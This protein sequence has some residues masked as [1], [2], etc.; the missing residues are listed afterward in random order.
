[1]T[2][3]TCPA[4][5]LFP[6]IALAVG[7]V[8]FGACGPG[9]AT[10]IDVGPETLA[11]P[12]SSAASVD[13]AADGAW[14]VETDASWL[15][16]ESDEGAF[17]ETLEVSVV[18]DE[19]EA[20]DYEGHI[21]VRGD[22]ETSQTIPVTM[23]FPDVTGTV[24]DAD[25]TLQARRRV[26]E[27][28]TADL[29]PGTHYAPGEVVVG[30]DRRT[31]ALS[32]MGD[33]DAPLSE[34]ALTRA[35]TGLADSVG[36]THTR[37]LTLDPGTS[38]LSVDTDD[39][40]DAIAKLEKDGRVRW[41]EPNYRYYPQ[42]V[43]DEFFDRQWHYQNIGLEDA[44]D[45]TTGDEIVTVGVIDIDFHPDHPD[46]RDNFLPGFNAVEGG[47]D[48]IVDDDCGSHGSHVA[49]TVAAVT[50]N[51]IGVAGVAPNVRVVPINVGEPGCEDLSSIATAIDYA[52]GLDVPG[53]E[54]RDEPV[55][56]I[57]MSLGGPGA[58]RDL[59][60]AIDRAVDAGVIVV[61]AGGNERDDLAFMTP[62][63][64]VMFPA[65]FP[66]VIG[67]AATDQS[68]TRAPYSCT[69]FDEG[70]PLSLAAP[71][72]HI[73]PPDF[74]T[75][76]L[77]TVWDY[78]ED[79]PAFAFSQ[80]TSMA[81]P[82]VAGVA[83]LMRTANADVTPADVAAILADT[84]TECGAPD[85]DVLDYGAGIMD[86]AAAAQAAED[87]L[88]ISP[89]EIEVRLYRGDTLVAD[90]TADPLGGGFDFGPLEAGQYTVMAGNPR[91][92]ELGHPG[93]VYA[94]H[95]FEIDYRGDEQV[96]LALTAR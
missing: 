93:T 44:W 1:M 51:G 76:V 29:E 96:D 47:S 61:A 81:S 8:S 62:P 78:E 89:T 27:V 58:S 67:V 24:S 32:V 19:L 94:E 57:N 53:A 20:G 65:G 13:I 42:A 55:D 85:C 70:P 46:L 71:G 68:D 37:L 31:T 33:A 34:A 60:E 17:D 54:P 92:G 3:R 26:A 95:S 39:V 25:G 80:G 52:A 69:A 90:E 49:G 59:A 10:E 45:V 77:S 87:N 22:S 72:G 75:G 79:A 23:R 63:C 74:S 88:E 48:V 2:K 43:N 35:S 41:A 30:L 82:H 11:F 91:D 7:G 50:D 4:R 12:G 56:V 86:A 36:A 66:N 15:E 5:S 64:D 84:A 16:F 14:I 73:Q 28:N 83:A 40:S 6:A 21:S 18:R 9:G 38:V